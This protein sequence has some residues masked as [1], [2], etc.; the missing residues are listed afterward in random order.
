MD[1][2]GKKKFILN[3]AYWIIVL[4]LFYVALKY[5]INLIMPFFIA[6]ILAALSRPLAKL[7]ASP[8]KKVRTDEGS[9]MVIPRSVRITEKFAAIISVFILFI[10]IFGIITLIGI[11]LVDRGVEIVEKVPSIYYDSVAPALESLLERAENWAS[12]I[13]DSVLEMVES[14]AANIVGT[15][16]SKVTEL[17]GKLILAISSIASKLPKFL[18][19]TV[20]CLIATVFIAIDF[21]SIAAFFRINLPNRTLTVVTEFKDSLVDIVWQFI[22]S[23]FLIFL[24]TTVEIT[25]GFL[26]IGQPKP[27]LLGVIIAVFDAF[28]IVGSGMILLPFSIITLASGM[29]GRGIGLLIV[30]LVVVIVR[31]VIE[32]KI[33]GKRVGLKPI[34]TLVCMYIGTK[35]FGGIGLFAIPIIAAII[36]DMNNDGTIHLFKTADTAAETGKKADPDKQT[37]AKAEETV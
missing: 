5:F 18:L 24:I 14:A 12:R 4:A 21:E 29:I 20:I 17:S 27:L 7:L 8:T 2:A 3:I 19:N 33:V 11:R 15:I 6:V 22:K 34:V 37:D 30:Y 10:V 25:L 26:I 13:D 1:T 32:P 23:Y 16:G 9:E 36:T 28:P 31:Q 35:L